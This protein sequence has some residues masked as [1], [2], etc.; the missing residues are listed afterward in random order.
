MKKYYFFIVLSIV[1]SISSCTK[2]GIQLEN[3]IVTPISVT[4][5]IN[6]LIYNK[7]NP[8][9]ICISSSIRAKGINYAWSYISREGTFYKDSLMQEKILPNIYIPIQREDTQLVYY[10][11]TKIPFNGIKN[12]IAFFVKNNF[13]PSQILTYNINTN[14]SQIPDDDPIILGPKDSTLQ[15]NNDNSNGEGEDGDYLDPNDP[16]KDWNVV[17][18][19]DTVG[20]GDFVYILGKNFN[21]FVSQATT[22][23][24]INE[25]NVANF[26]VIGDTAIQIIVPAN[27]YDHFVDTMKLALNITITTSKGDVSADF[28]G[29]PFAPVWRPTYFNIPLNSSIATPKDITI[30]AQSNLMYLC[31]S[32]TD[33]YNTIDL[34]TPAN[35]LTYNYGIRINN[36][37]SIALDN[38]NVYIA[39]YEP[40]NSGEIFKIKKSSPTFTAQSFLNHLDNPFDIIVGN[41]NQSLFIYNENTNSIYQVNVNAT[42]PID[43]NTINPLYLLNAANNKP[44]GIVQNKKDELFVAIQNNKTISKMIGDNTFA[45]VA[46]QENKSGYTGNKSDASQSLLNIPYKIISDNYNSLFFTDNGNRAVRVISNFT[47]PNRIYTIAGDPLNPGLLSP[48]TSNNVK[49]TRVNYTN[50]TSIAIDNKNNIYIINDNIYKLELR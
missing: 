33:T 1:L 14:V 30:D 49:A 43:M 48:P 39:N 31:S 34:S 7:A 42:G 11:P 12:R 45:I 10:I 16:N 6:N 5:D 20:V 19:R 32:N 4:G 3:N 24:K 27:L 44:V 22:T 8:L 28:T 2:I 17:G 25:I 26:V 50:P 38:D 46:G 40:T 9:K 21:K 47:N 37:Y 36:P 18:K 41:D 13:N 29:S 15:D 35:I 23:I